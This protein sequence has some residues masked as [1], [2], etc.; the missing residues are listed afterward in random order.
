MVPTRKRL[1][2]E[3]KR[4]G[5]FFTLCLHYIPPKEKT[6]PSWMRF[7]ELLAQWANLDF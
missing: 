2:R 5:T 1:E 3:E 4:S 6:H 7:S